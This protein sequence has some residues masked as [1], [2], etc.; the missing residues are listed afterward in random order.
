[1][2]SA[3]RYVLVWL[4]S[5]AIPAQGVAAATM[6]HCGP[7]HH[8]QAQAA[9]AVHD[10]HAGHHAAS[11]SHNGAHEHVATATAGETTD[12]ASSSLG[13]SDQG[14]CGACANC[15][16][17]FAIPVAAPTLA[18]VSSPTLRFPP[19]PLAFEPVDIDGLKRPPRSALA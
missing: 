1:M 11:V 12:G 9:A 10:Q 14:K 2:A 13:S 3:F 15:C 7:S 5:L 19:L 16:S 17:A 18:E 4:L 8:R 6:L